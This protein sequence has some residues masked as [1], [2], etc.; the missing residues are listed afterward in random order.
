M[1]EVE[2]E[3]TSLI[4]ECPISRDVFVKF[5]QEILKPEDSIFIAGLLTFYQ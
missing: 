3:K 4:I 1:A 5:K 2:L